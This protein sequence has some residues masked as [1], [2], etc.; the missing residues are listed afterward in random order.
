MRGG[1]LCVQS[2]ERHSTMSF[3]IPTGYHPVHRT[4]I[5]HIHIYHTH[6]PGVIGPNGTQQFP[7][8]T[9]CELACIICREIHEKIKKVYCCKETSCENAH[10]ILANLKNAMEIAKDILTQIE[11]E[12]GYCSCECLRAYMLTEISIGR[13]CDLETRAIMV[14]MAY[15]D[16]QIQ[17]DKHKQHNSISRVDPNHKIYHQNAPQPSHSYT[18]PTALVVPGHGQSVNHEEKEKHLKELIEKLEKIEEESELLKQT[19][20]YESNQH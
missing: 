16:V 15:A 9:D 13:L 5:K 2:K 3:L 8:L 11:K 6:Q 10:N 1:Y 12:R 20:L 18:I 14:C 7:K 17:I 4:D 19:I